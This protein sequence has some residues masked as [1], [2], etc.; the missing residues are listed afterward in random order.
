VP[1]TRSSRNGTE[2]VR[3]AF[4][5]R[6]RDGIDNREGE[7]R[8]WLSAFMIILPL[9]LALPTF[10]ATRKSRRPSF[11]TTFFT[12]ERAECDLAVWLRGNSKLKSTPAP[13]VARPDSS[14]NISGPPR[15][16]GVMWARG[17]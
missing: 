3:P 14:W 12:A 10:G 1:G 9:T 11:L 7:P 2:K 13:V 6:H 4:G 16:T 8:H 5:Q 15:Q 17:S